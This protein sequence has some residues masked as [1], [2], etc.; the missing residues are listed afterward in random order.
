[1][2]PNQM[3]VHRR[4]YSGT[5]ESTIVKP[6]QCLNWIRLK[7]AVQSPGDSQ[8]PQSRDCLDY[9]ATL[10]DLMN[11]SAN[12]ETNCWLEQGKSSDDPVPDFRYLLLDMKPSWKLSSYLRKFINVVEKW[13]VT[14]CYYAQSAPCNFP[15]G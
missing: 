3:S 15:S 12:S 4:Y 6:S 5:A 8:L 9:K 7:G 13:I 14:R 11:Q 1:M 10:H 2:F